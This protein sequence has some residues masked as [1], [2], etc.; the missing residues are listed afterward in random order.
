MGGFLFYL[1]IS[2][3][4]PHIIYVIYQYMKKLIILISILPIFTYA[5]VKITEIMYDVEGT[6]SGYEWIEVYNEGEDIDFTSFYILENDVNH[7]IKG[8]NP[9]L[10]RGQYAIVADNI[11]KFLEKHPN[12]QGLI[13][14]TAFSLNNKGENIGVVD[15]NDNL[16]HSVTY[17]P[18]IGAKGNGNSLQYNGDEWI[19]G[20]VTPGKENV[21]EQD[22]P[23]EEEEVNENNNISTNSTHSG[24]QDLTTYKKNSDIDIGI[25]RERYVT[26]HTPIEFRLDTNDNDIEVYWSYGDGGRGSGIEDEHTY[27]YPGEYNVVVRGEKGNE[28]VTTRSKVYVREPDISIKLITSGKHVDILLVNDS[29]FEVNLGGFYFILENEFKKDK[30]RIPKDTIINP[31]SEIYFPKHRT[32]LD[33]VENGVLKLYYPEDVLVTQTISEDIDI[34]QYVKEDYIELIRMVIE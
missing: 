2:L 12:Y 21:K 5:Q 6:D 32:F 17:D 8:D 10:S 34:L 18:E 31:K 25:A 23:S 16:L 13:F 26:I 27:M 11:D 19:S 14:D 20:E 24:V 7:K 15:N 4:F 29:D 28:L 33:K 9:T 3:S 30:F 1:N 22:E